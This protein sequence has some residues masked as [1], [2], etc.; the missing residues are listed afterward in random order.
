MTKRITSVRPSTR[1]KQNLEINDFSGGLNTRSS[2]T[3]FGQNQGTIYLNGEFTFSEYFSKRRGLEE[4]KLCEGVDPL[5]DTTNEYLIELVGVFNPLTDL[6]TTQDGSKVRPFS[7]LVLE[8]NPLES[9]VDKTIYRQLWAY[10]STTKNYDICEYLPWTLQEGAIGTSLEDSPDTFSLMKVNPSYKSTSSDINWPKQC[11]PFQFINSQDY[12]FDAEYRTFEGYG[13][14][15]SYTNHIGEPDY[16]RPSCWRGVYSSYVSITPWIADYVSTAF[17]KW[18]QIIQSEV[19]ALV[20]WTYS[21]SADDQVLDDFSF[22]SSNEEVYFKRAGFYLKKEDTHNHFKQVLPY[23]SSPN[24]EEVWGWNLMWG[25]VGLLPI[26]KQVNFKTL[27]GWGDDNQGLNEAVNM[28][29][30]VAPYHQPFVESTEEPKVSMKG[31]RANHPGIMPGGDLINV[32]G[33]KTKATF[34]TW[35]SYKLEPNVN[36]AKLTLP[37]RTDDNPNG[38]ELSLMEVIAYP[39]ELSPETTRMG[40]FSGGWAPTA[41]ANRRSGVNANK[42]AYQWLARLW[43]AKALAVGK[44]FTIGEAT[45]EWVYDPLST[46]YRVYP[47]YQSYFGYAKWDWLKTGSTTFAHTIGNYKKAVDVVN[48]YSSFKSQFISLGDHVDA[49]VNQKE[50]VELE[51]THFAFAYKNFY[52]FAITNRLFFSIPRK[53]DYIPH[54]WD[55]TFPLKKPLDKLQ[56]VATV[57]NILAVFSRFE[58]FIIIGSSPYV[59]VEEDLMKLKSL[60]TDIGALASESI[61]GLGTR[62]IFLSQAGVKEVYQLSLYGTD[63]YNIRDID[64]AISDELN[65]LAPELDVYAKST[66]FEGRYYIYI[67]SQNAFYVHEV[68]EDKRR[69]WA[70][71]TTSLLDGNQGKNFYGFVPNQNVS[72]LLMLCGGKC[73]TLSTDQWYDGHPQA[74]K[75]EQGIYDV[76]FQT[77][78]LTAGVDTANKKI[79]AIKIAA[80]VPG[81]LGAELYL[82]LWVDNF[83]TLTSKTPIWTTL[84]D[85]TEELKSMPKAN[86][87]FDAGTWLNRE[88]QYNL[89]RLGYDRQPTKAI[90]LSAKG[91]TFQAR[92]RVSS[93]KPFAMSLIAF[94]FVPKATKYRV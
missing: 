78:L 70:K 1:F 93:T 82:D 68:K 75:A 54:N 85:G 12:L 51:Q 27:I 29:S 52:G 30:T 60:N 87:F 84:P 74:L 59:G 90:K 22:P 3:P 4:V 55:F 21:A 40:L 47:T 11:T 67:P 26:A 50:L 48:N 89:S 10:N 6:Y 15:N 13:W 17:G 2:T 69:K 94:K 79:K 61:E 44:E 31:L 62:V 39:S 38:P 57:F 66:V 8:K 32:A 43:L 9:T 49:Y 35:L 73:Y 18:F 72:E 41:D 88:G 5:V 65:T 58:T 14:L 20:Q 7:Y 45:Q 77:D 34:E 19:R 71:W 86:L 25:L 83:H 16:K 91:R 92:V 23:K 63:N 53:F 24:E 76:V 36:P 37:P 33:P 81:D 80:W 64:T 56:G 42:Q 28:L 46:N